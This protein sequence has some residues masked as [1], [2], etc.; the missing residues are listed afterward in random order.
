MKP[1]RNEKNRALNQ[2]GL[3]SNRCNSQFQLESFR[4]ILFNVSYDSRLEF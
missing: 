4:F 2:D 1:R 3:D